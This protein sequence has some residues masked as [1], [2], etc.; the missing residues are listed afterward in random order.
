MVTEAPAPDHG[1]ASR[2]SRSPEATAQG[3]APPVR[4]GQL[5]LRSL[6]RFGQLAAARRLRLRPGRLGVRYRLF[7]GRVYSVFRETTRLRSH[8]LT[9]TSVI[10]VCFRLRG[11]GSW[12]FAHWLFQRACI[13]TTPF[14][15]GFDGF[16]TK[17]WM[18]EPRT[19]AY[20]GIYEWGEPDTA[21]AYLVVLLPVLRAV[22]VRGSVS[23]ELHVG[24]RLDEFLAGRE[25]ETVPAATS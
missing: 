8:G 14:W 22:S 25:A 13:L 23:C 5:V 15:S 6:A 20:A 12:R 2:M 10:E 7:D 17:L 1:D 11:V 4:A 9:N 21:R 24:A 3:G 16:A 19:G 18:V